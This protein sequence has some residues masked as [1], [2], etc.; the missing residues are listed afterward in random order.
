M[1]NQAQDAAT[2]FALIED[3]QRDIALK[4]AAIVP[5]MTLTWGLAWLVGFLALWLIDGAQPAF[6]LPAALAIGIFVAAN[7]AGV[8]V[9]AVL[10]VRSTRGIRPN[11]QTAFTGAVYGSTWS[12]GVVA[13]LLA[14]WGLSVQ[15]M[16]A[17]V[18]G[19]FY[20]AGFVVFAGLMYVIAGAIWQ[21][22]PCVV[23]GVVIV[24]AGA[25]STFLPSPWNYLFL[26][27][28]GG[29]TFL[30]LSVAAAR[31]FR[32]ARAAAVAR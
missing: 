15:G 3:Q 8:V 16:S 2:M 14:G 6:G 4:Q 10:G 25:S 24:L 12:L 17:D 11:R 5:R 31:W 23:A 9:S 27:V 21:A 13:L 18:A 26:A 19:Y 30:V 28:V 22:T 7:V 20:S 29:G 32:T 1:T